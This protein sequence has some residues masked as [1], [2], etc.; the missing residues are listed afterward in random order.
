MSGLWAYR[1]YA[2]LCPHQSPFPLCPPVKLIPTAISPS[3]SPIHWQS[4]SL[5]G[6]FLN[7][8]LF[9]GVTHFFD[10]RSRRNIW[11][12]DN[13]VPD[14]PRNVKTLNHAQIH[15]RVHRSIIR[16][17]TSGSSVAHESR[18]TWLLF[19]HDQAC[20][21]RSTGRSVRR[22]NEESAEQKWRVADYPEEN[23]SQPKQTWCCRSVRMVPQRRTLNVLSSGQSRRGSFWNRRRFSQVHWASNQ[24][25]YFALHTWL[26]EQSDFERWTNRP[27]YK[28]F[29]TPLQNQPTWQST[30]SRGTK[31]W[32]EVLAVQMQES[33]ARAEK[34]ALVRIGEISFVVGQ[35]VSLQQGKWEP[36]TLS[37]RP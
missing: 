22:E 29:Q 17:H 6:V 13:N 33:V 3:F 30:A 24:S 19:H 18:S 26:R 34:N 23:N 28:R 9:N 2:K 27:F 36:S 5:T 1:R 10:L 15:F 21:H 14:D 4:P 11:W 20:N 16:C 12:R 8:K 31:E 37:E 35:R 7:R 25:S 32:S